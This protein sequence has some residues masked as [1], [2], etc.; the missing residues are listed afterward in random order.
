MSFGLPQPIGFWRF[1]TPLLEINSVGIK[2]HKKRISGMAYLNK[3]LSALGWFK[4]SNFQ[5]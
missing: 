5:P 2:H 3:Q 4:P 1:F